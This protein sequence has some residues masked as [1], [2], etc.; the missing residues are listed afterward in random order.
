MGSSQEEN[1]VID[2]PNWLL[3]DLRREVQRAFARDGIVD[4]SKV[5]EYVRSRNESCNLALEDFESQVLLAATEFGAPMLL[6][7]LEAAGKGN[8]TDRVELLNHGPAWIVRLT[9]K[10]AVDERH[11]EVETHARAY[12][13]GQSFRL[14]SSAHRRMNGHADTPAE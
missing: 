2:F 6:E 13:S 3:E 8:R 11:F 9:E 5:A 14:G 10:G 4:V 7:C 12:A 1:A